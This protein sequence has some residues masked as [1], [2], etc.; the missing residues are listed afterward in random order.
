MVTKDPFARQL[1]EAIHVCYFSLS[2]P[3]TRLNG[4]EAFEGRTLMDFCLSWTFLLYQAG[5]CLEVVIG[6]NWLLNRAFYWPKLTVVRMLLYPRIVFYKLRMY[7]GRYK[8]AFISCV[9]VLRG[10][11]SPK[12]SYAIRVCISGG[13]NRIFESRIYL[14]I[15][16]C[17]SESAFLKP[18]IS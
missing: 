11:Y 10:R 8:S 17:R 16:H 5:C 12:L 2:D 1:P 3:T 14:L 6:P 13:T 4:K 7:I 15:I 9:R 18:Y